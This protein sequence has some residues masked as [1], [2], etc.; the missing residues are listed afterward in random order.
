VTKKTLF[1][2]VKE[3][4]RSKI[5][6]RKTSLTFHAVQQNKHQV[7]S[8]EENLRDLKWIRR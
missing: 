8:F 7:S 3:E 4:K 5:D 6:L 2:V 1:L